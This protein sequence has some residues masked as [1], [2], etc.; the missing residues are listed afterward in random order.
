MFY[1]SYPAGFFTPDKACMI[2]ATAYVLGHKESIHYTFEHI[3]VTE[4]LQNAIYLPFCLLRWL[5]TEAMRLWD[6]PNLM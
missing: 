3:D 1:S 6:I 2:T 4:I 5:P